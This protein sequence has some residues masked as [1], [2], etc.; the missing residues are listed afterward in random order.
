MLVRVH[1]HYTGVTKTMEGDREHL[2]MELLRNFPWLHG[3]PDDLESLV[4]DLDATQAFEAEIEYDAKHP[5]PLAKGSAVVPKGDSNLRYGKVEPDSEIV[6][7]MLGHNHHL[8]STFAAA[9]HLIA[10]PEPTLEQ[11]RKA[12][13]EADGDAEEAALRAHGIDVTPGNLRA[14]RAVREMVKAQKA[15]PAPVSHMMVEPGVP[16]SQDAAIE[17]QRAFQDQYV[18]PVQ[19]A[20]KHSKGTLIARDD[21]SGDVWLLKPGS[22]GQSP[23]AG[24]AEDPSS[25]SRRESAFYAVANEWGLGEN[26]PEADLVIIDGREYAAIKLLPW[27]YKTLDKL[28]KQNPGLPTHLFHTYLMSGLLHKWGVLD[29]VLGNPDRHANNLMVDG[30]DV[31]LI[32]H[33]SAMAGEGFDPA[34]DRNSFVPFYLRAW[35][36][37]GFNRL[38]T[39]EK[40]EALPRLSSQA[41]RELRSWIEDLHVDKLQLLLHRYGVNPEPAVARLAKLKA[42]LSEY[43]ADLAVNKLW[44]ET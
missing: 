25:Q 5:A 4:E 27:R 44:V 16:D 30:D 32:D 29:Y 33:G 11:A 37:G 23:A 9:R 14:L 31:K 40:L 10:A 8:Q 1:N 38:S 19:M 15:E 2:R 43:P 34:H 12:L 24:A 3:E 42:L 18:F 28:K 41:E 26:L 21:Q 17:I 6:H 22:G 39:E 13:W 35:V 20:G 7:D 36:S